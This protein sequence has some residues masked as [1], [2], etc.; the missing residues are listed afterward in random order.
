MC[1]SFDNQFDS[2]AKNP[3]EIDNLNILS[4]WSTTEPIV[5][6]NHG[7]DCDHAN[8]VECELLKL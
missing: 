5:N 7:C 3:K 4:T 2:Y 6:A 1:H 8:K